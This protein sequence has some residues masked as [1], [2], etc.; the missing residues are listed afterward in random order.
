VHRA[1][2][3][4]LPFCENSPLFDGSGACLRPSR[5]DRGA[6]NWA[7]GARAW[8]AVHRPPRMASAQRIRHSSR[9]PGR[10]STLL[11]A[12]GFAVMLAL[13]VGLVRLTTGAPQ[14]A[15]PRFA[16]HAPAAVPPAPLGEPAVSHALPTAAREP[17]PA[18]TAPRGQAAMSTPRPEL[19]AAPAG[20][21]RELKRDADGKL[22]PIISVTAL[23]GQLFRAAAPMKACIEQ[24]GQP[25]TGQ[26]TLSFTVAARNAKLAIETTGV[27]NEDTLAAYPE[28]LACM[29][30]TAHEFV[31]DGNAVPELGT[32]IYVR[33]RVRIERGVLAE[34][35]IYN[36]SYNP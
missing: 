12:A 17:H 27:E 30:Q 15:T 18:S 34:D 25:L 32:P 9:V 2:C 35:W 29:H 24:T 7:V 3:E 8:L 16:T 22:V 33:R 28:L 14:R 4:D 13:A 21:T 23:R 26:A 36:F 1:I 31:L 19:A 6:G 10:A 11:L 5:W 20:F